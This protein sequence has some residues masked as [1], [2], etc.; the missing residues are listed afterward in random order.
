MKKVKF[1]LKVILIV[2]FLF[3]MHFTFSCSS[4]TTDN[5]IGSSSSIAEPGESG[6]F[7]DDRDGKV[8]K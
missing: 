5:G 2:N 1:S 4:E 6:T 8:Y 7:T 3:V